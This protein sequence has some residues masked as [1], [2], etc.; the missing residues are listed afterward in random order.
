MMNRFFPIFDHHIVGTGRIPDSTF[1][2]RQDE[3][4]IF[5]SRIVA[6]DDHEIRKTGCDFSH[7]R[8]FGAI[9]VATATDHREDPF[10][11]D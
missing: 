6:G 10:S 3:A 4:W 1:D 9:A 2:F 11:L 7:H 8:T 5:G